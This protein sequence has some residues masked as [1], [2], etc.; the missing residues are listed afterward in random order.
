M[1]GKQPDKIARK[2]KEQNYNEG[3]K[4][5]HKTSKEQKITKK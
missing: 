2:E 5:T 1:R 3:K 4:K